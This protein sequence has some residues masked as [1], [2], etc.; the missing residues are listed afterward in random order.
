VK[1]AGDRLVLADGAIGTELMRHGASPRQPLAAL[2][3][4]RP[5]LVAAVHRAYR[6]AG[7]ELLTANTFGANRMQ[8]GRYGLAAQVAAINRAGVS[9]ARQCAGGALVASSVGP[10]GE[11]DDLPPAEELRAIFREQAAVLEEAGVDLF[12]C[13]TFG[14]VGELRAAIQGIRDVS[15]RP[16]LAQM[17]FG[18]NRKTPLGL[19]ASD[20]VNALSDLPVAGIGVNCAVGVGTAEAVITE[21]A[22]TTA[23]PLVARPNAGQP[24]KVRGG[25]EYPVA[26]EE[27]A[28]M[29]ARL[30]EQVWIVGGCCGTTPEHIA[31]ARERLR[32]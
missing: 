16:I 9:I 21:M 20:V 8:L 25:W 22:E 24:V 31:A 4:V 30:A 11:Q 12:S 1:Q 15:G 10:T 18:E 32:G 27:F 7:A 13:E 2:N 28:D 14:D 17:T 19:S 5:L 23:L 26:A 6:A 29:A 3:I